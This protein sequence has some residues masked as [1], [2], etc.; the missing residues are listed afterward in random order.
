MPD[1]NGLTLLPGDPVLW[2]ED[3]DDGSPATV[4]RQVDES[5]YLIQLDTSQLP[6]AQF[7]ELLVREGFP[8]EHIDKLPDTQE[9]FEV[10]GRHLVFMGE[11]GDDAFDDD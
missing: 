7:R 3:D 1:Q 8:L 2:R 5:R 11:F 9:A 6:R 10:D 4:L